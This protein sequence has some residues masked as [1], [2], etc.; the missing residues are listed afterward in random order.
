LAEFDVVPGRPA[1]KSEKSNALC[2]I[3]RS[4]YISITVLSSS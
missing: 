2:L 3:P 4:H 1:R